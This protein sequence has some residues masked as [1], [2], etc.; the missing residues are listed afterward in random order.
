M[1]AGCRYISDPHDYSDKSYDWYRLF[2]KKKQQEIISILESH[3]WII[4]EHEKNP[5]GYRNHPSPQLQRIHNY[6]RM[7]PTFGKYY[8]YSEKEWSVYRIAKVKK[9]GEFPEIIDGEY[10]TEEIA[11]HAV[12]LKRID[13]LYSEDVE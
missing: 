6:F 9:F 11:M 1:I 4:S 10:E 2:N 7:Q 3:P 5:V 13:D 8:I 12:F